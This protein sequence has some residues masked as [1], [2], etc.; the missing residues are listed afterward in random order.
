MFRAIHICFGVLS[1]L[2]HFR[3]SVVDLLT[4]FRV[5]RWEKVGNNTFFPI[6]DCAI[7]LLLLLLILLIINI[8]PRARLLEMA[9]PGVVLEVTELEP[10]HFLEKG[11]LM[12][13]E[14]GL[15]TLAGIFPLLDVD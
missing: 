5:D 3:D 13:I 9:L 15:V 6:V 14:W 11:P 2:P 10:L 4:L 1:L 8:H 7:A 12:S